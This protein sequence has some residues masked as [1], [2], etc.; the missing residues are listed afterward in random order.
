MLDKRR[1]EQQAEEDVTSKKDEPVEMKKRK[2]FLDLLLDLH[3]KGNILTEE[4]IREEVDTFM[5]AVSINTKSVERTIVFFFSSSLSRTPFS[6][7]F[8]LNV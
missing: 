2:A 4:D 5:F 3:I 1:K 8:K 6:R 7:L